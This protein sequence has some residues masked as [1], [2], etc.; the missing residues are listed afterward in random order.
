[1]ILLRTCLTFDFI[2]S[3]SE[4]AA[5]DAGSVQ[6]PSTWRSIIEDRSTMQ[7]FFDCYHAFQST[8]LTREV[9]ECLVQLA[10]I[11]R[12]LLGDLE[13]P[14]Y[15]GNLLRGSKLILTSGKGLEHVENYHELCRFI[16][17][18]KS[19]YQLGELVAVDIY[20]EWIDLIAQLTVRSFRNLQWSPNSLQ[21]L[22]NFWA[23]MISSSTYM[24][25]TSAARPHRLEVYLPQVH[26][27]PV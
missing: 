8:T 2:G 14:Q 17:R 19:T 11:R 22:L 21:Y 18:V 4:D 26:L 1:M 10:S 23:K 5:D 6:A 3:N 15:L 27:S 25:K 7:L 9:L 24:L 13:R 20:P 16:A 12:S